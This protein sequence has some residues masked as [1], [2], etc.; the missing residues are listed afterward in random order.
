MIEL[1]TPEQLAEVGDDELQTL[2]VA[3]RGR[4][5]RGEKDANGVAHALEVEVRRR[6]RA[7][8]LQALPPETPPQAQRPWWR[9]W[10]SGHGD[11]PRS[12][13]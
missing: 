3:W 12:D 6:A 4:A 2:A 10:Q 1:P 11:S 7:S 13:P 5:L 9:F 8:Q